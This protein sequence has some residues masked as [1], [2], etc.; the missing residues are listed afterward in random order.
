MQLT[1]RAMCWINLARLM[2]VLFV[3]VAGSGLCFSADRVAVPTAAEL[4]PLQASVKDV[5]K[6][7]LAAAKSVGQQTAL[8]ERM[9]ENVQ[10]DAASTGSDYALMTQAQALAVKAGNTELA[11]KIARLIGERFDVDSQD[12]IVQTLKD[13]AKG[14]TEKEFHQDL[15]AR[16]LSFASEQIAAE[17][18]EVAKD[19]Y[20]VVSAIGLKLKSADLGKKSIAG[21]ADLTELKK[22]A[23][24]MPTAWKALE[25]K[26]DD[27]AANDTV[28]RYE[29][30]VKGNWNAGLPLLAKSSDVALK[31]AAEQDL[32]LVNSDM[33]ATA[34]E[35]DAVSQRWWE[36]AQKQTLPRLKQ[37]LKLR[38][39]QW[40]EYA[41]PDLK[42]FSKTKAE[43]RLTESEWTATD[44][45]ASKLMSLSRAEGEL[46]VRF[47]SYHGM[48]TKDFAICQAAKFD[49]AIAISKLLALRKLRPIRFRPYSTAE[50]LL[51]AAI[52]QRDAFAGELFDGTEAD[53]YA[54]DKAMRA[55]GWV[56]CDVAGYPDKYGATRFVLTS[57]RRSLK[58]K[59][60]LVVQVGWLHG[61]QGKPAN[62]RGMWISTI[63]TWK[64][65][66]GKHYS[67]MI[68][69]KPVSAD[70]IQ[71]GNSAEASIKNIATRNDSHNKGRGLIGDVG[72]SIN[73]EGRNYVTWTELIDGMTESAGYD[74]THTET[75]TEWQK[76]A[77]DG[78]RPAMVAA[79]HDK[80]GRYYSFWSWRKKK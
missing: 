13:L 71:W 53:M 25:Q 19:C 10:N 79:A 15:A 69:N 63:H 70:G 68:L 28:G 40:A 60:E 5:F 50:G 16:A 2:S 35:A 51:V 55:D 33:P 42:G 44:G 24:K 7:D 18:F 66:D 80:Q 38:A 56:P 22:L 3:L 78:F 48:I 31:Q 58:P 14:P 36:V 29:I 52:W 47:A 57:V 75:L 45:S 64:H 54:H 61:T 11:L 17:R 73:D 32:K 37:Q 41:V 8:A 26:A 65:A 74:K 76:L 39:G 30:V 23:D 59:E 20:E 62:E 72:V 46:E 1:R 21:R 4:K 49:D 67:D 9:L 6:A 27:P 34:E 12:L 77:A 43:Q